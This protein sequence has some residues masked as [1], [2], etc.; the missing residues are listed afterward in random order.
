MNEIWMPLSFN[1]NIEVSN[2]GRLR[3]KKSGKIWKLRLTRN[4][5]PCVSVYDRSTKKSR[6]CVIH[7]AV[8][9]LFLEPVEGKPHV[10]HKDFDKTNNYVN[11]LEWCTFQENVNHYR[12]YKYQQ[13]ITNDQILFIRQS[14]EVVG[15]LKLSKL[16]NLPGGYI[17]N[18]ANGTYFPDIHSEFIR[19]K[20]PSISKPIHQ[21][22]ENGELVAK[23]PSTKAAAKA[24]GS[25]IFKIQ[26]VVKGE[27]KSHKGF[28]WKYA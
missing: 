16:M 4:G 25:R 18:V 24:V 17:M 23:Y 22:T 9:R 3:G 12:K 7:R 6:M 26:R 8:A 5:Y 14:I 20:R 27:R 13:R 28:I 15:Y 21:L 19:E 10:N 2:A 1:K 11:N